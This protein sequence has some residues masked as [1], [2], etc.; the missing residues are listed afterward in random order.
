MGD[1]ALGIEALGGDPDDGAPPPA[2]PVIAVMD[3]ET[4]GGA[5]PVGVGSY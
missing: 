3:I 2:A 5:R 4:G 1:D